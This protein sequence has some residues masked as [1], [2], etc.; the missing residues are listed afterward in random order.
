MHNILK[1][2]NDWSSLN[3]GNHD[4]DGVCRSFKKF[5]SRQTSGYDNQAEK[6]MQILECLVKRGS[7]TL[8]VATILVAMAT[9]ILEL[10]TNLK[11]KSPARQVKS[12]AWAYYHPEWK[13]LWA[14]SIQKFVKLVLLPFNPPKLMIKQN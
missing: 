13:M 8:Q 9:R 3:K 5:L 6:K 10:A 2:F 1:L 7:T 4:H 12:R 11:Q 14:L